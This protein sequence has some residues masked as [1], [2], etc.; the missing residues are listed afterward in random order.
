MQLLDGELVVSPSDLTGFV[1]CAHLTQLDLAVTRGERER[2]AREDGLLDVLERRGLEH[3]SSYLEA[4]RAL[5]D[6][7]EIAM[8]D[9]SRPGLLAAEAATLAAMRAGMPT[10]YQA[11]FFDGRRRGHADFLERVERPSE[12]GDWSYE[13]V[14]T[15]LAHRVKAAALLQLGSYSAHVARLQ[16]ADPEQLHVVTGRGERESFRVADFAA[17]HR[18]V[19]QRF[20][21]VV[22]GSALATYPEPVEHCSVCRWAEVCAAQRRAD[23]HLSL[24]AG[25]RR[26]QARK[27]AQA[28]IETTSALAAVA[29]T[30]R[31]RGIGA[32]TVERLRHQ[33]DLQV[34]GAGRTPPLFELVRHTEDGDG[35]LPSA[36][37]GFTALP[38]PSPGDLFLDLEGDPFALDGGLEYLF[39]VVELVDGEPRYHGFWGHDRAG[40][41]AAFEQLVDLVMARRSAHPDLHVYH[42]ASYERTALGRLAGAHGTRE[43]EVDDLL[44][45]HVLVDLHQ[46][47]RQSVRLST[48]SYG[49]KHVETLYTTRAPGTVMDAGESVVAY[50]DYLETGDES[51]LEAIEA[52]NRDDCVSLLG[53]RE[54]L[55]ARRAEAEAQFGAISRPVWP[56]APERDEAEARDVELA[57][58]A[59]RLTRGVADD[60]DQRDEDDRARWLLA[61]LLEWHRRE[62]R[63]AWWRYFER[64]E[65][66]DD[67]DFV[68][69]SEC[70]GGLEFQGD[71]GTIK[72]SVVSRYGFDPQEHKFGPGATPDDPATGKGAGEVVDIG[73][74]WVDLKRGKITAERGH[75]R[76]LI[77]SGPL[78]TDT[79][80]AAIAEVAAWVTEHGIDAPGPYRA[81]RDLLLR[82]APRI[83]G[84]EP[85]KTLAR[86]DE[87]PLS[88]ARRLV[89]VLDDTCLPVQG[90]PG[91]GKTFTGAHM[92]LELVEAGRPVGV[93]AP[94]H[95]AITQLLREVVERAGERR[96]DVRV[97]QKTDD[98]DAPP[99]GIERTN[100]NAVAHHALEGRTIDVL[101]GTTWLWTRPELRAGVAVLFVDEAGQLS[102]ADAVAA[103]TAARNVVLLGDPQQL[104]QPLQ[105]SHPPGAEASAL[106]HVLGEHPTI[107][108]SHGVFLDATWR[109]HPE[110]CRFVSEVAYEGRLHSAPG[111]ERQHVGGRTGL[112]FE[113]VAHDG[114]RQRSPEEAGRVAELVTELV[115]SDCL[116]QHG[117]TRELCLDD[118]IVI[119]PYNA[120]TAELR[121]VL[122]AGARV[123]TVDKFQ[124]QEGL[125]A[126]YS[127]ATSSAEQAPRT[128][129]F[130]YDL[131]RLNVAV[132]RA[133]ALAYVVCSP[134]LL[135]VLCR[136]PEQMRLVN[137]L[138]R[139][140]ELVRP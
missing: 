127:M 37:R 140:V 28:G 51:R 29:P 32:E 96:R 69:D 65:R 53:L 44:R 95:K 25:M 59:T 10:I 126:I 85:G 46:V 90:P 11:T 79:H 64:V 56:E 114:N 24:V 16:G 1:A 129:E 76:A 92:I 112:R 52:Y 54:W 128:M 123:G 55:E 57:E 18:A 35:D 116:D 135:R 117:V 100:D 97:L 132:S 99:D 103:G 8:S 22:A 17:Y 109:M 43:A 82:R 134:E 74:D 19:E 137:A 31:V 72:Q 9:T 60:P 105:G 48:E 15:K 106:G 113:P 94:T 87:E 75:P 26:D 3:E 38:V 12:L 20:A 80:R 120:Q 5:G 84:A 131:H 70:I 136:T 78:N 77:P 50:E 40:E 118:V 98:P 41:R 39:G 34:R 111:R 138:C 67:E 71:V 2:P 63:P 42:Y 30:I 119:A 62:A 102:L 91:A 81:V 89:G 4:R 86:D 124:G 107:P 73:D 125:V 27:L 66:Y 93:T 104:A 36:P 68:D 13:A 130:L 7:V 101:G 121:R 110:V 49:L 133:R 45:S 6:V 115:G 139:Y 14:D 122:P 21:A 88:A 58:L 33:A 47:V 23:D 61:Q 83:R 108:T